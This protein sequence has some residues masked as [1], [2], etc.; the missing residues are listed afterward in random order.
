MTEEG[1]R[2][3]DVPMDPETNDAHAGTIRE[4]LLK[5][6]TNLWIYGEGFS[7]KKPFGNSGWEYEIYQALIRAGFIEGEL[8]EEGYIDD[9][10]PPQQILA[11]KLITE[12]IQELH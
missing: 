1:R 11:D 7:G 3:L 4:Y 12:A 9:L 2:A 10:L 6:L 5:L 8:D